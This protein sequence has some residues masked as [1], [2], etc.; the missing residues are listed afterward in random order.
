MSALHSR[1]GKIAGRYGPIQKRGVACSGP[2]IGRRSIEIMYPK[3]CRNKRSDG[4]CATTMSSSSAARGPAARGVSEPA[5]L[6][7]VPNAVMF[8][9]V[10]G[11]PSFDPTT[12]SE[13]C[14]PEHRRTGIPRV[15]HHHVSG[16]FLMER[17]LGLCAIVRCWCR[18]RRPSSPAPAHS[19]L[20][21]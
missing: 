17:V 6:G 20:I 7:A 12:L 15:I 21:H 4:W 11:A 16:R 19:N 13:P 1:A 18:S 3:P 8:G 10:G 5:Y 2:S 9:A 14:I